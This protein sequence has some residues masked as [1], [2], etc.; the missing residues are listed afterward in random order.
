MPRPVSVNSKPGLMATNYWMLQPSIFFQRAECFIPSPLVHIIF[1]IP[2]IVIIFQESRISIRQEGATS[3]CSIDY[4]FKGK[5]LRGCRRREGGLLHA[6][7][8][9]MDESSE[10]SG[11][12]PEAGGG[13]LKQAVS[14]R[15]HEFCSSRSGADS[16]S[17][18]IDSASF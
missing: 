14:L 8:Q 13:T 10:L 15:L 17:K 6:G 9:Q 18:S 4:I 5:N 1:W 11:C 12:S 2:D 7:V 16:F 3:H